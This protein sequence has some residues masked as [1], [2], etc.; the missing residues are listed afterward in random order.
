MPG[1]GDCRQKEQQQTKEWGARAPAPRPALL[2]GLL[3]L[4]VALSS[5]G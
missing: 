2:E 3:E 4:S 1:A 5:D